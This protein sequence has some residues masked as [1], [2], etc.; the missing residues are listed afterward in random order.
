VGLGF[1][2]FPPHSILI[3]LSFPFIYQPDNVAAEAVKAF[4]EKPKKGIEFL[5]SGKHLPQQPEAI[6]RFLF[7][8][9]G[10]DRNK[11]GDYLGEGDAFNVAVLRL[12]CSY[13]DFT[14]LDFDIA[15]RQLLSRF[16]LPGE[17]Q[18]IDRIMNSFAAQYYNCNKQA[19]LFKGADP[20]YVLA[21]ATIMLHTDAH[22]P[23]V[24]KKMTRAE[25]L[26]VT[27]E[28]FPSFVLY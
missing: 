25:W 22:S 10:I 19:G 26:K 18:K 11:L 16:R 7:D 1:F 28:E 4:N 14:D 6:S 3:S 21:F 9:K 2:F 13:L 24:K 12:F 20:V 15:M 27:C 5:V 8:A 17:A 23:M